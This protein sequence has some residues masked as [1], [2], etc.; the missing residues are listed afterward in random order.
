MRARFKAAAASAL[1]ATAVAAA[2]AVPAEATPTFSLR[3]E[4][5]GATLDPGTYYAV[6]RTTLARRGT[7]N[8]AG[9]C[10]MATGRHEIDGPTALGLVASAAQVNRKL[11]PLV[12]AEDSFGRRLCRAAEAIERDQPTS[13]GWLF[14]QNGV[15]P[16]FSAEVS[17]V[18]RDGKVLWVFADFTNGANTGDELVLT[19]P[20]RTT[21][22][23]IQVA[24]QAVTF[25]GVASPAPDGTV[26]TG[27]ASLAITV[28]G[29]ATVPVAEG[30]TELRAVGAGAGAG[31]IPSA[32]QS[33]CVAADLEECPEERGHRIIGTNG[34]DGL[35]GTPGP[36][37]IRARGGKDKVRVRGGDADIVNCGKG[38]DV[39]IADERD[40][41]KRCE[42]VRG[43]AGK[44]DKDKD[45]KRR[46]RG[47]GGR[48]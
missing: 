39:V 36:D 7:L 44:G 1:A 38:K 33:V 15:S 32:P 6:P 3:V 8:S 18:E 45:G 22:G 26:V 16:L 24:V 42:R 28:G 30:E 10:I 35:A 17:P 5:P 43:P 9:T 41:L 46:K 34:K 19:A 27:G 37:R 20:V 31:Q 13:T 29:I 2:W 21:P 47:G 11:D 4:V 23:L 48:R 14:K 12:V 25:D 40:K